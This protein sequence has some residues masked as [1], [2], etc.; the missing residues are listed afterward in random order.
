M[1]YSTAAITVVFNFYLFD[2]I[3]YCSNIELNALIIINSIR[4]PGMSDMKTYNHEYK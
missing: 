3:L 1:L 4:Q 2:D